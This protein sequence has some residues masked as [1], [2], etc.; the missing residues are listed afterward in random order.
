MLQVN[1]KRRI[2]VQQLL[3]H[4]WVTKDYNT[5]VKWRSVYEVVIY[6]FVFFSNEIKSLLIYSQPIIIDQECLAELAKYLGQ[7]VPELKKQIDKVL[8]IT[9]KTSKIVPILT[10]LRWN[11]TIRQPRTSYCCTGKDKIDPS[12]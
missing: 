7:P 11:M 4:P 1:P 3:V 12:N 6:R 8:R 5:P 9:R 10:N 2:T